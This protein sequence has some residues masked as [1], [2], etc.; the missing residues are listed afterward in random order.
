MRV[1]VYGDGID[2]ALA[3][4]ERRPAA[5][6]WHGRY[7]VVREVLDEWVE[8]TPWWRLA[9]TPSGEGDEFGAEGRSPRMQEQVWRVEAAP[10]RFVAGGVYDLAC[11]EGDWRL[12]RVAD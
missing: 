12:R 5:F 4:G 1:R 6:V 2:V 11:A 3:E 8:R 7:Y 10:G 9:L